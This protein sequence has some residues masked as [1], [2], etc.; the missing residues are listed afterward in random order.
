MRVTW[1]RPPPRGRAGRESAVVQ[2]MTVRV[3]PCGTLASV[4]PHCLRYFL[5]VYLHVSHFVSGGLGWTRSAQLCLE[6]LW[7]LQLK[8]TGKLRAPQIRSRRYALMFEA[9]TSAEGVRMT[10]SAVATSHFLM[11]CRV[12]LQLV[13]RLCLAVY[14]NYKQHMMRSDQEEW[15]NEVCSIWW[16]C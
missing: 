4:S 3:S 11:V 1:I 10:P 12:T 16:R 13:V 7:T 14:R 15:E 2:P 5:K 6:V 9:A 8:S